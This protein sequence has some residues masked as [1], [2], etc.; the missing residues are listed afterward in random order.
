[1]TTA[2]R[3]D[4]G[5]LGRTA[6]R[7]ILDIGRAEAAAR[8]RADSQRCRNRV[9]D[10]IDT[11]QRTHTALS[12]A[13]ITRR[14]QVNAQYLQRHRDLKARAAA[15]RS[16]LDDTAGRTAA[17]ARSEGEEALAVEN[18]MLVEQNAQL[19]RDLDTIRT[20]LRSLRLLELAASAA[21]T[22]A[23]RAGDPDATIAHLRDERDKALAS[24]RTAEAD[25]AALRTL[26]QRL[27]VENSRLLQA[28]EQQPG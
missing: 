11:M 2:G 22:L 18:R 13:E 6:R 26:N 28:A 17:A 21:G 10:V 15:I 20:E 7:E 23:G 1:M 27:M 16:A 9:A 4:T 12:D 5:G 14:A 8:R 19:R 3:G 24:L 25:L